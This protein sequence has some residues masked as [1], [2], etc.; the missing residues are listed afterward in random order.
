M[1]EICYGHRSFVSSLSVSELQKYFPDLIPV[2]TASRYND[3]RYR[4][5]VA[6]LDKQNF[7]MVN[8]TGQCPNLEKGVCKLGE[9]CFVKRDW[10][11]SG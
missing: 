4:I 2:K 5:G 6:V 10:T 11:Q 7:R 9:A 1:G 8:M 3:R